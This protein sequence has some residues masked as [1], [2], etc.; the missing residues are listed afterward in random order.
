MS[1]R[2]ETS[3]CIKWNIIPS[4]EQQYAQEQFKDVNENEVKIQK[5]KNGTVKNL[6][7]LS[8]F[9]TLDNPISYKINRYDSVMPGSNN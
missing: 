9:L 7:S 6:G 4:L 1:V 5:K 3:K 2:K 8:E